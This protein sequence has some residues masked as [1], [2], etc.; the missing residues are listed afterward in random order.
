MAT[1]KT[2]MSR[3][4]LCTTLLCIPSLIAGL[5]VMSIDFGNEY[6]KIAIVKPGVPMEIVLNKESTRKTPTA[7]TM[8]DGERFVGD[9]ALNSG[10]RY[11]KYC[12]RYLLD[13]LGKD[14]DNPLVELYRKRFPY[15]EME[16]DAE[17][18]M[19][20]F[21]HDDDITYTPEELVAMILQKAKEYA[22]TFAE[23]TLS[24]AVIT[25][26]PFFS[27][28]ERRAM[29]RAAQL[30]GL[31][32]LQLINDNT[33]VAL[34]YGIFRQKMFD[35]TPINYMFF[36]IGASGTS[37]TIVSYQIVKS[38]SPVSGIVDSH[39]QLT[40][41]GIGFDRTLGGMEFQ[42]RLR[43]YLAEQFNKVKKSKNDVRTDPRAMQKL[44]K[45]AGRLKQVLSANADHFAQVE[46]LFEDEDFRVK[47][48]REEFEGLCQDLVDRVDH[49]VKD[50]VSTAQLT[51]EDISEVILMGGGTRI[52]KVQDAIK[53]AINKEELGKG[54]NTDEAAALGAVYQAAHLG[55]G[56]KV[57]KFAIKDATLYPI[58]V[59]FER[60][61]TK[62]DDSSASA[63]SSEAPTT[64]TVRRVLFGHM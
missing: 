32:V 57:K 4:I 20:I 43:D 34:N 10:I 7:I 6:M 55:K 33:A 24:E 23:Q 29:L 8:K 38:K 25:V 16:R 45:E 3:Y 35:A 36:D 28:A 31:N 54:I 60:V 41:K 27:Q 2:I 37:A 48:T 44:Y 14:F 40:I 46:S 53:K 52:P 5:A 63:A 47:V 19:V 39:P 62:E 13:V 49:V 12:Y 9:P 59:E 64:K 51:M 18:G 21:K 42:L 17:T 50:A 56:F 26:P 1:M 15:H 11:P 30:A 61:K 22:E 58:S